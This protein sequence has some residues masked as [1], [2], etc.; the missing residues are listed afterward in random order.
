M[1][2]IEQLGQVDGRMEHALCK[3]RFDTFNQLAS[4]RLALLKQL[5]QASFDE[6]LFEQARLKTICWAK[7]ISEKLEQSR[8]ERVRSEA[9]SGYSARPVSSGRVV[10]RSL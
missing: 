10:N 5:R 8:Q 4:E 7:R 1:T 6:T 3:K 2:L 9:L